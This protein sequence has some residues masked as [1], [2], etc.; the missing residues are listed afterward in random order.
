MARVGQAVASAAARQDEVI[1]ALEGVLGEMTQW[2]SYRRFFRDVNT[3]RKEHDDVAAETSRIAQKTLSKS[4]QQLDRGEQAGLNRAAERQ[5]ELAR[6]FDLIQ[7]R[8]EKMG[9]ELQAD[10]PLAADVLQDALHAARQS[11]LSG[12]MRDAAGQIR[13]NQMSQASQAQQKAGEGLRDVLDVLANRREHELSRLVKKLRQAEQ[14]LAGLRQEQQR[15]NK[16]MHDAEQ[17]QNE[18]E[19]KRELE[20]LTREQQKLKEEAE[21]QARQLQRLQQQKAGGKLAGAAQRMSQ[22]EQNAS[23]GDAGGAQ[24]EGEQAQK[25]LEEAQQELAE[26]RQ[27][28][29]ADLA[30]EELA[31]LADALQGLLGRQQTVVDE[32]QRLE[33]I[34]EKENK[35]TR[36]QLLSLRD[37][38][39][40]ESALHDETIDFA[41]KLEAAKVFAKALALAA[42]D[43]ETAGALLDQQETG[44][45][46]QRAAKN[47]LR[48]FQQLAEALKPD[49]QENQA[50]QQGE[51]GPSGGQGAGQGMPADGVTMLAE[52]K[53]LRLMQEDVYTRTQQ[54]EDAVKRGGEITDQ[55]KQ[56]LDELTQQQGELAKLLM[57]LSQQAQKEKP[58]DDPENLPELK[59]EEKPKAPANKAPAKE[60]IEP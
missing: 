23:Q 6:Q 49:P 2:D 5:A 26:A 47:A 59:L 46:S 52:L 53:M 19:R 21:R 17:N 33:G 30:F 20:R 1:A 37:L 24:Q 15:L 4:T 9:Q 51:E 58:A 13:K 7:Q 60:G 42:R 35:F 45:P 10:D 38:A 28:A 36:G 8:M 48:Q 40:Q 57:D 3:L 27:Q 25:D 50:A 43:L 39:A 34:R 22:A 32:I 14:D 11:G 12:Q 18:Q 29:E 54:L 16:Q 41:G 44:E 56:E 55:Q 31:R